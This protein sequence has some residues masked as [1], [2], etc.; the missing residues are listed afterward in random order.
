MPTR[1]RTESGLGSASRFVVTMVLVATLAPCAHAR[2]PKPPDD[3][4]LVDEHATRNSPADNPPAAGLDELAT[5]KS[6]ADYAPAAAL[7]KPGASVSV[8]AN[9][10]RSE[11]WVDFRRSVADAAVP[12]CLGP[13]AARHESFVAEGL[14]RAPFLLNAAAESA[15]R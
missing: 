9:V 4:A 7:D 10:A 11:P 6:P 15:C 8:R 2:A 1:S 5:R 13:D 14:L 3:V 12:N